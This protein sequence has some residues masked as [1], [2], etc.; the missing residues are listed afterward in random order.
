MYNF[1]ITKR[2]GILKYL[3]LKYTCVCVIRN[4][5]IIIAELS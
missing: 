1:K 4:L 2:K 3:I 5:N